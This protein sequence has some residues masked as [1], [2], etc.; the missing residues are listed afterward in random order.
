MIGSRENRAAVAGHV[1]GSDA[2][3]ARRRRDVISTFFVHKNIF[4]TNNKNKYIIVIVKAEK[5]IF[6]EIPSHVY[7]LTDDTIDISTN[8]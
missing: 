2:K 6:H 8:N 3:T 7:V 4:A 5:K 1:I